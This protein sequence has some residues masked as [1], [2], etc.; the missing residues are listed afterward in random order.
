MPG[1]QPEHRIDCFGRIVVTMPFFWLVLDQRGRARLGEIL[2]RIETAGYGILAAAMLWISFG[3]GGTGEFQ[4]FYLLFLPIVW[5]AA[6]QG[7]AGAAIAAFALQAG[8]VVSVQWLDLIAVTVFELQ[9][10]GAVLAFVGLFIGA[11][12]DEKQRVSIELRQTLRLAAAGEMA[13]ALAHEINQ[14]LTALVGLRHGQPA[15]ARTRRDRRAA[16]RYHR[17]HDR[18]IAPRGGRCPAAAGFLPYRCHSSGAGGSGRGA[19]SITAQFAARATQQGVELI[20]DPAPSCLLAGR[21]AAVGCDPAQPADQRVRRD[22]EQPAD[23]RRI[24]VSSSPVAAGRV[25][26]QVEDSGPGLS[27]D[28]ASR[29]FEAF[30]TTKASGL[31]L[32]LAISRAIA[33]A[34]G[35]SLSA[36]ATD[37]G[38]FKLVLPVEGKNS[39]AL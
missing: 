14:P 24:R 8:I 22:S 7:V 9:L 32:G 34:H 18:R 10:L 15:A 5:A 12:V 25:C 30:Q 27:E 17:S 39:D 11:V 4:Y 37:H 33:E 26:V 13:A 35:G 31:G 1:G 36:E 16:A 28:L 6:R 29:L 23:R 2:P 19:G 21:S 3:L 38:V 20:V